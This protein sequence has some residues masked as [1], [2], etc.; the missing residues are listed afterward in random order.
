[1]NL[2]Y[3]TLIGLKKRLE[4]R[5]MMIWPSFFIYNQL[6]TFFLIR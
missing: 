4:E 1:M 3:S 2:N 6:I 5:K